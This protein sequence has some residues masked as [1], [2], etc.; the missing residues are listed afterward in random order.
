[1]SLLHGLSV[2]QVMIGGKSYSRNMITLWND[3]DLNFVMHVVL[4]G[5]CGREI[6]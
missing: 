2:S 5:M 1:M 6:V 3:S 4:Y